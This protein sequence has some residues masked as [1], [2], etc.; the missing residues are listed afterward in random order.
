MLGI[1][2]IVIL[3]ALVAVIGIAA[4]FVFNHMHGLVIFALPPAAGTLLF[5]IGFLLWHKYKSADKVKDEFVTTAAHRFRTPLTRLQW[6]LASLEEHVNNE[7]GKQLITTL[8][9]SLV[10]LTGAVNRLLDIAESGRF[11]EY[12]DYL[13]EHIRLESIVRQAVIDYRVGAINK[14][15]SLSVAI[16]D[17]IPKVFID[18]ERIKTAIYMLLENAILYTPKDGTIEVDLSRKRDNAVFS[19]R[20]SGIGI[21]KEAF[22]YI[23]SKFFR[24]HEALSMDTDRAGLGLSLVKEIIERHGGEVGFSSAG[25]GQGSTFWFSLPIS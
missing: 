24:A 13:F 6:L 19:I 5:I 21:N 11:S 17:D 20:D 15:I 7:D 2:W 14:N 1:L 23:F 12:Y 4:Q 10:D 9:E 22:P 3:S 18:Q 16:S 25:R 8:K